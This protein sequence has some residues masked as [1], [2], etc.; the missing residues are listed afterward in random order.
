LIATFEDSF[1]PPPVDDDV[2]G[3]IGDFATSYRSGDINRA[4]RVLVDLMRDSGS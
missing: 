4:R 3:W 2:A 1:P